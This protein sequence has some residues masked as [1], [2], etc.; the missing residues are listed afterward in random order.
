MRLGEEVI[1]T[2]S[3][4]STLVHTALSPTKRD[5]RL[6]VVVRD[7]IAAHRLRVVGR[8]EV[9][10]ADCYVVRSAAAL[11]AGPLQPLKRD[12]YV[13][14]CVDRRGLVLYERTV[15]SGH[16]TM[17]RTATRVGVGAASVRAADFSM[18]GRAIPVS[19]GGGG[20]RELTID[21]RPSSGP[22]WD[23]PRAPAGFRHV[24]RYAVVPSQ[25]QAYQS[26]SA[27]PFGLPGSLVASLDDVYVRGRDA[28]VIEQGSTVNDAKFAPPTGGSDVD[29][30][31]VLGRGQLL[32]SASASEIDAEPHEG[33]RFVR[34]VGTVPPRE[35]IALARSMTLQPPGTEKLK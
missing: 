9:L 21:S 23:I 17:R 26:P 25:P 32:L 27:N 31:D 11:N 16:V 18:R 24:G 33:R 6:D 19:S 15:R 34:I 8:A 7:A 12:S 4:E 30:G 29:L 28:I 14:S 13:D 3:S 35:L 5:V 22:F 20:V 10:G 2:G 1:G